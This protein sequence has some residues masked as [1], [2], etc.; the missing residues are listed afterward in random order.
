MSRFERIL[1]IAHDLKSSVLGIKRLTQILLDD[2]EALSG[3]IRRKLQL[4]HDSA[5]EASESLTELNNSPL[6]PPES[7]AEPV[8]LI[9]TARQVVE[10]FRA[11][12]ECKEQA[13]RFTPPPPEDLDRCSVYGRSAL[14]REAMK[15][16]VSNALKF[17]PRGAS[18][19]VRVR[20][21]NDAACFAVADEGPGLSEADKEQL[22]EPFQRAGPE[23]TEG[24]GSTGVG[25]YLVDQVV[26]QHDGTIQ[27]ESSEGQGSTFSLL[28]P[29]SS[30]EESSFS[31]APAPSEMSPPSR[32]PA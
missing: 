8:D 23:P 9:E 19:E 15:N 18:I 27:V 10:G 13:L 14:L 5:A 22:F 32:I 11:Q 2:A 17:S 21:R 1:S 30:P 25:L 6:A 28:F 16:L 7:S 29:P 31:T 20:R 12:A 3:D 4:I 24:E 26:K